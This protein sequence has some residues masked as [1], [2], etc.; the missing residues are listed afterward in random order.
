MLELQPGA[1]DAQELARAQQLAAPLGGAHVDV[2]MQHGR[3]AALAA[4]GRR[5]AAPTQQGGC[6]THVGEGSAAQT[7]LTRRRRRLELDGGAALA[8]HLHQ[9]RPRVGEDTRVRIPKHRGSTNTGTTPACSGIRVR[10]RTIS[11]AHSAGAGGTATAQ[12]A[13][14]E[15]GK[16][17]ST[18]G[19][20]ATDQCSSRA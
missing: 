13:A 3:R 20:T 7:Q 16:N 10:R 5:A 8:P 12:A 9:E 2:A 14:A 18:D 11:S 4:V 1:K 15:A 6:E 19:S 17:G